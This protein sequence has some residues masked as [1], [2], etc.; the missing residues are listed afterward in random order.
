MPTSLV[1]PLEHPE[2]FH[3]GRQFHDHRF[4]LRL[5]LKLD[6]SG[7]GLCGIGLHGT[8]CEQTV[9]K[10]EQVHYETRQT[11][12]ARKFLKFYCNLECGLHVLSPSAR[13]LL[14]NCRLGRI[15]APQT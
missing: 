9:A 13:Y 10:V 1:V 12:F 6:V 11:L 15:G 7:A 4:A 14:T 5:D 8:F 3:F 2:F